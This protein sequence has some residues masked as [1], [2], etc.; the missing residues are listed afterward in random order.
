MKFWTDNTK[1]SNY[2]STNLGIK[3]Q[4][5]PELNFKIFQIQDRYNDI[6]DV[7]DLPVIEKEF[8][9]FEEYLEKL[10]ISLKKI[11][12]HLRLI[13]MARKISFTNSYINLLKIPLPMYND[14]YAECSNFEEKFTNLTIKNEQ[15]KDIQSLSYLCASLKLE[16]KYN[17]GSFLQR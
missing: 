15:L 7:E 1:V 6:P 12:K 11:S 16:A 3:L 9:V 2:S 10:D 4:N 14:K 13:Y 8:D 17:D 5:V